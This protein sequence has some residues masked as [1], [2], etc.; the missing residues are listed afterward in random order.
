MATEGERKSE[1]WGRREPPSGPICPQASFSPAWWSSTYTRV[2][3]EA[4]LRGSNNFVALGDNTLACSLPKLDCRG[5]GN[6][7]WSDFFSPTSSEMCASTFKVLD[8][9][10]WVCCQPPS[11]SIFCI[12]IQLFQEEKPGGGR[13]LC[14]GWLNSQMVRQHIV[15]E[16]SLQVWWVNAGVVLHHPQNSSQCWNLW[17]VTEKRQ[18]GM[19]HVS[20]WCQMWECLSKNRSQL[21]H[22]LTYL[23]N[24]SPIVAWTCRR[25]VWMLLLLPCDVFHYLTASNPP[26]RAYNEPLQKQLPITNRI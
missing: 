6:W 17:G 19:C 22:R 24:I 5:E 14:I 16:S 9:V 3:M 13:W 10:R 7:S 15:P 23:H 12:C 11:H 21:W 18:W 1:S 8:G 4:K 20:N 25:R 26:G 2:L